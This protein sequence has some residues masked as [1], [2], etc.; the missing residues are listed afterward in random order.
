[1]IPLKRPAMNILDDST[2]D[3]KNNPKLGSVYKHVAFKT[4]CFVSYLRSSKI[5]EDELLGVSSLK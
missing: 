3:P 1:M 5:G 4:A 2:G